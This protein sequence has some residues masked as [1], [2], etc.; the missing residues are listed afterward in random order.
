MEPGQLLSGPIGVQTPRRITDG[1]RQ[2]IARRLDDAGVQFESRFEAHFDDAACALVNE[3]LGVSIVD[4]FAAERWRGALVVKRFLS[5]VPNY[6]Y[7]TR[8]REQR[9]SLLQDQFEREFRLYLEEQF[10]TVVAGS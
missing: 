5:Y 1:A 3:G 4:P 9:S 2:A 10:S 7:L 6:V 8:R